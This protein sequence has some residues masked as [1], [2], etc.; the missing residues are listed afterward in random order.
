MPRTP[1]GGRAG[2]WGWQAR[3]TP[4]ASATGT[5]ACSSSAITSHIRSSE[6]GPASVGRVS[7][8]RPASKAE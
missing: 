4:P 2:S 3:R 7:V 6:T 5:S 1:P 8:H